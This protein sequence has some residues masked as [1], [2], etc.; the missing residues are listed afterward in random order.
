MKTQK[1]I[2]LIAL[3][4]TIIVLLILAIVS[5]GAIKD[6]NIIGHAQNVTK[7]YT[8]SQ[9]DE[10]LQ[11]AIQ[12]AYLAGQGNITE[13]NL[14]DALTSQFGENNFSLTKSINDFVIT[15]PSGKQYIVSA[16]GTITEY[17][18]ELS[19]TKKYDTSSGSWVESSE[20]G[21]INVQIYKINKKIQ[22]VIDGELN[23]YVFDEGNAYKLVI[24]GIGDNAEMPSLSNETGQLSAWMS[25]FNYLKFEYDEEKDESL[26]EKEYRNENDM[27]FMYITD[28]E[29]N[30]VTNISNLA[31][32]AC[33]ELA[34][35]K[36]GE[37]VKE[38]GEAAFNSCEKLRTI[39]FPNSLKKINT[40][41]F[42]SCGFE[43]VYLNGV[44]ELEK[45]AFML[46]KNLQSVEFGDKTVTVGDSA[47]KECY[48]LEKI[49]MKNVEK[50]GD[51][52][53]CDC[54]KLETIKIASKDI[55]ITSKSFYG[56][57]G[58]TKIYVTNENI[59][60]KI[61]STCTN[62][63]QLNIKVITKE[64]MDKL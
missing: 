28:V 21:T 23:D 34:S 41:A 33:K 35:C 8:D 9:E 64:E 31:F 53:F 54:S 25:G 30:N 10:K 7:T 15:A 27:L 17:K 36:I 20:S 37:G 38:I 1:G 26:V 13:D 60:E 49:D 4:I 2:T 42:N 51:D 3:I 40:G 57:N 11:L 14:K 32:I 16:K 52:L 18:E 47:F 6:S 59:K 48:K 46:C 43:S 58:S 55:S 5:I 39:E 22:P 61:K 19:E 12:E 62:G 44:E 24:T 45:N 29:I 63:E 50:L 56:V